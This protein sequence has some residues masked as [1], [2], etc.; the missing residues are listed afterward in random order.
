[1]ANYF[2]KNKADQYRNLSEAGIYDIMIAINQRAGTAKYKMVEDE[3]KIVLKRK[4]SNAICWALAYAQTFVLL[5][6]VFLLIM[7]KFEGLL[8]L[9]IVTGSI[10]FVLWCIWHWVPLFKE[11]TIIIWKKEKRVQISR[12][13][14][15]KK[16][17][18]DSPNI[19]LQKTIKR[20]LTPWHY[21]LIFEGEIL[22]FVLQKRPEYDRVLEYLMSIGFV[23]NNR[24]WE[25]RG[26]K[27]N[28]RSVL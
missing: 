21:A 8:R 2:K 9:Y 13:G 16:Y 12:E 10:L 3:E 28:Q 22:F 20:P 14:K 11:R 6:F 23:E 4:I 25:Y 1:M 27:E 15:T 7:L 26:D 17:R 24:R 5:F 19:S 18:L